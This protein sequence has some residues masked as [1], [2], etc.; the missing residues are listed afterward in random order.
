M[1]TTV[2]KVRRAFEFLLSSW[3]S[4]VGLLRSAQ[5]I[6]EMAAFAYGSDIFAC[7]DAAFMGC[8]ITSL[9]S[10]P[11]RDVAHLT[12]QV[13]RR[14]TLKL[15]CGRDTPLPETC[16]PQ[17]FEWLRHLPRTAKSDQP[18][19]IGTGRRELGQISKIPALS[20]LQLEPPK[21]V[22]GESVRKIDGHCS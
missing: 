16:A 22:Q 10:F 4:D 6:T 2:T 7:K 1:S 17:L 19:S 14:Y 21:V 11:A 15:A 18:S 9:S 13:R 5:N 8:R 20:L 12:A 3:Y